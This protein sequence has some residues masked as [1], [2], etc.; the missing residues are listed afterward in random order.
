MEKKVCVIQTD[1]QQNRPII[2][3]HSK[4][5]AHVHPLQTEMKDRDELKKAMEQSERLQSRVQQ[6]EEENT[7]LS[8]QKH[9][10]FVRMRA[11]SPYLYCTFNCRLSASHKP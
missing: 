11:V 6:L 2:A 4:P 7:E 1:F 9:E 3:I 8:R 5:L 10:A